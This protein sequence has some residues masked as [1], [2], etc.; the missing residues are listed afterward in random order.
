MSK[1]LFKKAL[2]G[3]LICLFVF[4]TVDTFIRPQKAQAQFGIEASVNQAIEFI[5]KSTLSIFKSVMLDVIQAAKIRVLTGRSDVPLF[6]SNIETYAEDVGIEAVRLAVHAYS[7]YD[8]CGATK[9]GVTLAALQPLTMPDYRRPLIPPC[10]AKEQWERIAKGEGSLAD[11]VTISSPENNFFGVY[12]IATD[13]ID[14]KKTVKKAGVSTDII[15]NQGYLGYKD[16]K[17]KEACIKNCEGPP[18]VP[19]LEVCINKC[20]PCM[21]VTPG[22]SLLAEADRM[23]GA[24][25]DQFIA[26]SDWDET[27]GLIIPMILDATT[28]TVW[29]KLYM[30]GVKKFEEAK[31]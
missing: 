17:E 18:P 3:F 15:A 23:K 1:L 6:P 16:C 25:M 5:K 29:E 7:G 8:I 24:P 4:V 2:A 31:K 28:A 14:R 20:P 13:E 11:F 27:I 19:D 26:T 30:E 21:T 12:L 10:T 22:S 9:V